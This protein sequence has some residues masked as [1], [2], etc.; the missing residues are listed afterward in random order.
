MFDDSARAF[1]VEEKAFG[2]ND[3]FNQLTSCKSVTQ[4]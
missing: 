3:C 2:F 4:E 1:S